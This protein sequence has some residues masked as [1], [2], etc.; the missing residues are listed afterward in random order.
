MTSVTSSLILLL[1]RSLSIVIR[2]EPRPLSR[3]ETRMSARCEILAVCLLVI[4]SILR[5]V[6]FL[7]CGVGLVMFVMLPQLC[8]SFL[9]Q[10]LLEAMNTIKG[11][12]T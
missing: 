10:V 8:V 12:E 3:R 1:L 2:I 9:T 11:G 7:A 6:I 4:R 5:L